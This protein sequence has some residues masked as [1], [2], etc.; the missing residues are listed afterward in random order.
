MSRYV[1]PKERDEFAV[2]RKLGRKHAKALATPIGEAIR[3]SNAALAGDLAALQS[4][5]R[6]IREDYR[7]PLS[8]DDRAVLDERLNGVEAEVGSL[9]EFAAKV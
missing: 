6:A 7:G 1:P 3:R 8:A 4:R 9:I 5:I 2:A